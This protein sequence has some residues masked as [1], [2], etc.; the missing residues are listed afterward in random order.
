MKITNIRY[1]LPRVSDTRVVKFLHKRN[2]HRLEL[3][4]RHDQIQI[5]W[6][7]YGAMAKTLF[8]FN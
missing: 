3:Y 4:F 1:K 8:L 7:R 6:Y 2:N 5:V